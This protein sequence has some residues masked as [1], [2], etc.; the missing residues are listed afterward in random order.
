MEPK[1]TQIKK[2]RVSPVSLWI[3]KMLR[4]RSKAPE[5]LVNMKMFQYGSMTVAIQNREDSEHNMEL[6]IHGSENRQED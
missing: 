2:K 1:K 4:R 3:P 5:R 6:T